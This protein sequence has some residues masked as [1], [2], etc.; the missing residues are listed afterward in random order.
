[1]SFI[2]ADLI[3][4]PILDIYRKYYGW[5]MM[6]YIFATFYITMALAGYT[7]EW[8]FTTAGLV[9]SSRSLT[10]VTQSP[11]WDY[12]SALNILALVFTAVLVLRFL[13]TGGLGMLRMM[14]RPE[15]AA[16]GP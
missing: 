2:F 16:H 3:V 14:S 10:A 6:G 11:A 9:P 7:V 8:L 1:V 5:R 4:L 12:T 15:M 13:R